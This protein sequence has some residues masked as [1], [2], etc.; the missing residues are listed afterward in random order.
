MKYRAGT[1]YDFADVCK[2]GELIRQGKLLVSHCNDLDENG[3][4]KWLTLRKIKAEL[5][6]YTAITLEVHDPKTKKH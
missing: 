3:N 5:L 2:Q 4:R 1:E 6:L